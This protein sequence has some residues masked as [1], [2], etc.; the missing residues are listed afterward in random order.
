MNEHIECITINNISTMGEKNNAF[1]NEH[2]SVY[3]LWNTI[4]YPTECNEEI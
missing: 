4:Q 1:Q 2:I 3:S